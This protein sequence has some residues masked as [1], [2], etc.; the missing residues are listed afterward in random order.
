MTETRCGYPGD[1]DE[2]L[3]AYLYDDIDPAA[4]APFETHLATC[5]RCRDELAAM[6]GVRAHLA[7]WN[8]PEPKF[9]AIRHPHASSRSPH[10]WR[11]MPAWAQVAAALLVLGVSAGIAN[12]DVRYDAN[13]FT[14]RSGWLKSV[15]VEQPSRVAQGADVA[16][17]AELTALEQQLRAELRA[18][19]T[20]QALSSRA[21][22]RSASTDADVMR[23]VRA[24]VDE[25]ERRQQRELALRL[26]QVMTDVSAQRQA[27][28][29]RIDLSLHG[30][31]NN[32]GGEVL[33]LR[34]SQNYLMRVNQR[35]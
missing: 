21:V 30:V 4:R 7:R 3:I 26:A 19:R 9:G 29:R 6:G 33:K 22:A 25:A 16:S 24:L 23:K 18:A 10:W 32:L 8:P 20:S 34:Q 17:K 28:L 27:D 11:D 1:R 15:P 14:V 5:E 31:E 2:T 35:Q 12:L 13:G